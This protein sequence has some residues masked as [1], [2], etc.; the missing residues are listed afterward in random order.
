MLVKGHVAVVA[1]TFRG[2]GVVDVNAFPV[3]DASRLVDTSQLEK[4]NAAFDGELMIERMP[5]EGNRLCI[6]LH[7]NVQTLSELRGVVS[8]LQSEIERHLD[9]ET[10]AH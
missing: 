7:A 4:L 10:T 5:G 9:L 8:R 6:T 1:D 3:G 2:A